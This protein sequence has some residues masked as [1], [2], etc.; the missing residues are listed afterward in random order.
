MGAL[1]EDGHVMQFHVSGFE[2]SAGLLAM[3]ATFTALPVVAAARSQAAPTA[4][5]WSGRRP[6]RLRRP[7]AAWP[8]ALGSVRA[9]VA[10]RA[11]PGVPVVQPG[12]AR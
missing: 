8:K 9:C 4:G 3:G 10:D 6:R 11:L 7:T 5:A 1:G 2:P 12:H